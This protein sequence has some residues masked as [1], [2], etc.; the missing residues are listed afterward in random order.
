VN[1][2]LLRSALPGLLWFAI[3]VLPC[4]APASAG[5]ET[6]IDSTSVERWKLANGL[7]ISVRHVPRCPAVAIV[8]AYRIGRDHDPRGREGLADLA[9]E[10]LVTAAA[11]TVPE[12]TREQ[13]DLIR[14]MGWNLQ[15][16]PRFTL[17]S[18]VTPVSKFPAVLGEVATRMRGV[19]VT[20]SILARAV[21]SVSADQARKYLGEVD[22]TLYNRVRQVALGVTDEEMLRRVSGKAL[23]GVKAAE[24]RDRLGKLYVPANAVVAIAG[25]LEDVDLHAL[26]KR[27]FE[28]IP[29]GAVVADPPPVR[30]AAAGHVIHR[31]GLPQPIGI[32]GVIAPAITDSLSPDF[33]LNA[34]LIGRYCED[35]WGPGPQTVPARF[36]YSLL[37][38]PQLVQFFPPIGPREGDADQLG[39][40]F[41]DQIE[42]LAISVM[43]P[44]V[45]DEVRQRHLWILG[46]AMPP[47]VMQ[48]MRK[49]PATL[50]TLANTLAMR[51]LWGS[52]RF[53]ERYRRR[54]MSQSAAEGSEWTDYFESPD[55]IVRLLLVPAKR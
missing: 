22:L 45:F 44:N 29:G 3:A 38:D 50:A 55:H 52:D 34:L 41:Q 6:L 5:A 9:C 17:I 30:L 1:R 47:E 51:A 43:P 16:S 28:D 23:Q 21:R 25:N 35:K 20:D 7:Q 33:Y 54:F 13:I 8:V 14:P 26:V 12:R 36:R 18:E 49:N 10:L 11:G 15:V 32:V 46:G 2:R 4:G 48:S 40:V 19:T 53:W 39:M 27:L 37:A 31:A 42:K 24:I